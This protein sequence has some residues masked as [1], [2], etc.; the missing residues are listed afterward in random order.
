MNQVTRQYC[1]SLSGGEDVYLFVLR[2][3]KGT[4]AIIS[5][6]GATLMA[7]KVKNADGT[8]NDIVLGF[9]K[10]EDYYHPA[11]LAAYP[12]FG[13]AVGRYANRIT[14][15]CFALNGQ[16]IKLSANH[17]KH[18]LHGGFSGF[19]KKVWTLVSFG[20]FPHVFLELNYTSPHG[21]EGFP[22][23]LE[24]TIRFELTDENE[25]SYSYRAVADQP[26]AVNLTHHSYFNLNN[27]EGSILNHEVRI[28]GNN[29]LE[30]DEKLL[31]TGNAIPV[32]GTAYDFRSFRKTG[33]R[34]REAGEYDKSFV[35]KE[36]TI[37]PVLAA[38]ARSAESGLTLQVYTTEPVVHFYS[39]KW[40]PELTGKYGKKYGPF[41]GFCLETHVHPNAINIPGFPDTILKPGEVYYQKTVYKILS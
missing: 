30:Q 41:S 8:T 37:V 16:T 28:Y 25:F 26:T 2:N 1:G 23:N 32:D 9:E 10:I 29:I 36:K 7:F 38:E 35:I 19:D 27:G 11:Y 4:E 5:S 18:T 13:C 22:G 31:V 21:E 20:H 12:W 15:A 17:G 24:T 6:Y 40:I 3:A 14:N 34:I 33:E 39:G